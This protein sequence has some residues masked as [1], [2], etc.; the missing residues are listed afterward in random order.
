MLLTVTGH[1]APLERK[2]GL[3]FS[4]N[5]SLRWSGRLNTPT[6]RELIDFQKVATWVILGEYLMQTQLIKSTVFFQQLLSSRFRIL[7][8]RV[9][10]P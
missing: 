3:T 10:K 1:T 7:K 5:I 9:V 8:E 2:K 6:I 4:I